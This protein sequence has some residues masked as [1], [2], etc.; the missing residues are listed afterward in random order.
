MKIKINRSSGGDGD[1][2]R[3]D[4]TNDPLTGDL[5]ISK[6]DPEMRLTDTGND[7]FT[8]LT[9]SDTSNLAQRLN[10]TGIPGSVGK[11]LQFDGTNNYVNVGDIAALEYTGAMT[12]ATW[13]KWD[14][15]TGNQ[16]LMGKSASSNIGYRFFKFGGSSGNLVGQMGDGGNDFFNNLQYSGTNFST[17]VWYHLALTYDGSVGRLYVDGSEVANFSKVTTLSTTNNNFT[18]GSESSTNQ[19]VKGTQ[20]EVCTWSRGLTAGE[21]SDLYN[22]GSGLYVD[23]AQNF[24]SSGTSQG[25]NLE[26][27]WHFDETSGTTA[28]D[29]SGNGI[30]GTNTGTT[31]AAIVTGKVSISSSDAEVLVWSSEDSGDSSIQGIQ[32]YGHSLG[33]TIIDGKTISATVDVTV[34]DEAYGVGWDGNLEVPTKNAV[35]DKIESFF[36]FSYNNIPLGT[37][38]SIPT[39]QQM[40]VCDINIEGTLDLSLGDVCII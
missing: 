36:Q 21:V 33:T 27:L 15:F 19:K 29:S 14:D 22:S 24:P 25:L 7:Q 39:N 34:P 17:G 9:K 30:D 31:P 10:K 11:A 13:V 8:R 3:L 12:I 40:V 28:A 18:I 2:L 37:T 26:G 6:S 4:T 38:I 1:F 5:G 16:S 23:P 20:D 32:T 35:Y